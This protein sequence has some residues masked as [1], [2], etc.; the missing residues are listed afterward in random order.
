MGYTIV[1]G[2][3][4]TDMEW[5]HA[6]MDPFDTNKIPFGRDCDRDLANRELDYHMTMFHWGR[7]KDGIYLPKLDNFSSVPCEIVVTGVHE[8][9]GREGSR[10]LYLSVSPT[11][12][13]EKLS[14]LLSGQMG[15]PTS[16]FLHITLAVSKNPDKIRMI[17]HQIR[18]TVTFPISMKIERLDLYHIWCPTRKERSF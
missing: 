16:G 14:R 5:L 8:M 6:L 12:S 17:R 13:Y 1:A 2:F 15:A 10:L 7:E 18:D 9:H 3:Q 11:E 4:K